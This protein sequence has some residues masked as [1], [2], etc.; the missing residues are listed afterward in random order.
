MM[1]MDLSPWYRIISQEAIKY[2]DTK[3]TLKR[4]VF[5]GYWCKPVDVKIDNHKLCVQ[6]LLRRINMIPDHNNMAL[7]A[8]KKNRV[9]LAIYPK[10]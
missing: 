2:E 5:K 3:V 7:T 9:Y 4:Y 8:H 1:K 6:Q 10:S